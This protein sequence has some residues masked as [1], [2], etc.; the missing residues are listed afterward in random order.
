LSRDAV[1][2][3]EQYLL[4]KLDHN[5]LAKVMK[6]LHNVLPSIEYPKAKKIENREPKD[7]F[8]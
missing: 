6:K 8:E 2:A 5:S 7:Y 4:D 1:V 3:Y